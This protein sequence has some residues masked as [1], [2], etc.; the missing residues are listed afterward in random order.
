M[1]AFRYKLRNVPMKVAEKSFTAEGV[2]FPAGS[3][4]DRRRRRHRRAVKAAVEQFGLT[5]A[6]LAAAPTV[7]MHEADLPRV[8]IYSSWNN[9]QE[10]GWYRHAFD[11][12][13]IPFDLIFKERVKQ[14]N[15]RAAYDVILMPTQQASRQAVFAPPAARPVP[16]IKTDKFK[17][18]G[19]YGSSPDIT[20]G[21]GGEGV[22][23]F[24]KFLEGGGTLICT[25]G[26]VQFPT[27]LG[28][29]AHRQRVGFDDAARSTRRGR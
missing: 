27:E 4:V 13:G 6:S 23:A 22:D 1:I 15:L 25:G 7:A 8:A 18:L 11:Q 24:A 14:G 28:H 2:E 5:A 3:F 10:I 20:G 17:F 16:Y 21:M 26:A 19:D 29:G 12:F 9:T